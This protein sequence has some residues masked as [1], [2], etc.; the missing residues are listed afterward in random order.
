LALLLNWAAL[1]VAGADLAVENPSE[2][3]LAFA[4]LQVKFGHTASAALRLMRGP[5]GG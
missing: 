4:A 1:Q 3:D 5:L 2:A